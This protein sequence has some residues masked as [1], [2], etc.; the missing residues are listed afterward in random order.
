MWWPNSKHTAPSSYENHINIVVQIKFYALID[1][2]V[3]ELERKNFSDEFNYF[4]LQFWMYYHYLV[5]ILLTFIHTSKDIFHYNQDLI[6]KHLT[7]HVT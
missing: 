1:L 2:N 4:A 3:T 5:L 6:F 7:Y